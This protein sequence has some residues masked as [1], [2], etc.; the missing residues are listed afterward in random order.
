V[1]DDDGAHATALPKCD[2]SRGFVANEFSG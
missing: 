2:C 1:G